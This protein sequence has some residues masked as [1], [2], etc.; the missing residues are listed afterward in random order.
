M[1][2]STPQPRDRAGRYGTVPVAA[3]V[4]AQAVPRRL[5]EHLPPGGSDVER[6]YR[7]L[8]AQLRAAGLPDTAEEFEALTSNTAARATAALETAS[9]HRPDMNQAD[10]QQWA[11]TYH[12]RFRNFH[13]RALTATQQL[14]RARPSQLDETG[15]HEVFRAW[16]DE[17][18]DIYGMERPDLQ[19]DTDA[20]MGGGG[21]YRAADHSITMSPNHPSVVTLI[22]ETR[23]ALQHK[24]CGAPMITDD[25]ERD[26]R[27][28]SLSLYFRV[29][30]N[31]FTRLA[32]AGRIFHVDPTVFA[33]AEVEN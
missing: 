12:L 17:I 24:Q 2:R 27:A 13:A 14:L 1:P 6:A 8:Q 23:H 30:P 25:V 29:R 9:S 32:R 15:R 7:A 11:Q 26:A 18:S 3:P 33:P 20:D 16:V 31:Q 19:W 10:D 5:S 21:F 4:P 28:W 22:H